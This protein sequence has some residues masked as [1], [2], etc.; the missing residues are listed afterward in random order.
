M[1]KYEGMTIP[2]T[3]NRQ[4]TIR[5]GLKTVRLSIK[6]IHITGTDTLDHKKYNRSFNNLMRKITNSLTNQLKEQTDVYFTKDSLIYES[7][8]GKFSVSNQRMIIGFNTRGKRDQITGR[9]LSEYIIPMQSMKA[10]TVH[11][12]GPRGGEARDKTQ[13]ASENII[14]VDEETGAFR[15][16][17]VFWRRIVPF[18]IGEA[19]VGTPYTEIGK[20]MNDED[21]ARAIGLA[22]KIQDEGI[23]RPPIFT[24]IFKVKPK[25][26]EGLKGV[27]TSQ[28]WPRIETIIRRAGWD[29]AFGLGPRRKRA[30]GKAKTSGRDSGLSGLTPPRQMGAK[31]KKIIWAPN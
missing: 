19:A 10:Q 12:S 26:G 29:D 24:A 15:A 17:Y 3:A 18:V 2:G 20:M 1:A 22:Q 9:P 31:L 6:K 28:S 4:N 5:N 14:W 30:K 13:P 16:G 23:P 21:W 11:P 27:L 7:I 25:T 8:Y